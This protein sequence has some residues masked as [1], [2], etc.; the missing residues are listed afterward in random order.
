MPRP[1]RIEFKDAWYHVMNRGAAQKNIFH[2]DHHRLLFQN[3]LREASVY[4]DFQIHA[5]CLMD[6]HYH[7][8]INTPQGNLSQGMKHIN[9][10]YTQ[11]FNLSE[12]RDGSLFRGRYRSILIDK[13]TYLLQVSRYI[14]LN[15]VD[16]GMVD[17]PEKYNWS[18][19]KDYITK[20][21]L[22]PWLHTHFIKGMVS[23]KNQENSY[24]DFVNDGVDEMTKTFYN[25]RKQ[26]VIFE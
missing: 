21:R 13:D 15:P 19:Y 23:T 8:L 18:S 20:S 17:L 12:N 16:A 9:G 3:L 26:P 14:H 7:L 24:Q 2:S 5:Y 11:K 22:T 6:N 1:L 4:Y 25:N 10:I